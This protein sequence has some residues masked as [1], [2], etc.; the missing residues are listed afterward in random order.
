MPRSLVGQVPRLSLVQ[1]RR[2]LLGRPTRWV[3]VAA[4]TVVV[5]GLLSTLLS[6][7]IPVSLWGSEPAT[8][9]YSFYN[10][11]SYFVILR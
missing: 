7:S 4:G 8:D 5:A 3:V 11:I 1:F 9:G 2:W 10:T 6:P